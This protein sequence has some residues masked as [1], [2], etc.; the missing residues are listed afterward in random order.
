MVGIGFQGRNHMLARVSMVNQM[1]D[2]L[3]DKYVKPREEVHIFGYPIYTL[4]NKKKI[5]GC[6]LQD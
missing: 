4:T 2:V 5:T 1:G 6:R 3:L